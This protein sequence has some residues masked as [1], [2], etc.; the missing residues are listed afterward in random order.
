[1]KLEKLETFSDVC[2]SIYRLKHEKIRKRKLRPRFFQGVLGTGKIKKCKR[3]SDI[4]V[5]K[6][7]SGTTT[8]A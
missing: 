5:S 2:F 6:G 3:Y 7:V 8:N 1:M 4:R